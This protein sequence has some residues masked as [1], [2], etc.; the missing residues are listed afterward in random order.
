MRG[1]GAARTAGLWFQR[2]AC[3]EAWA[4]GTLPMCSLHARCVMPPR[5]RL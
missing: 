5:C 3:S 4:A 2:A 1:A